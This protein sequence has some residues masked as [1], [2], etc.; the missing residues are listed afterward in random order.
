MRTETD[1]PAAAG[2]LAIQPRHVPTGRPSRLRWVVD[3]LAPY[4]YVAP[5]V[6]ILTVFQVAPILYVIFLS[7]HT[8]TSLFGSPWVGLHNYR[9]LLSDPEIRDALWATV[10]FTIGTVPI[11]ALLALGLALLLFEKL[12]GIGIFRTIVLLPF[13]TPVVATTVVWQ[14]IFNPQYGFLD[15]VLSFLHLST[16]DWFVSP[17]WSMVILVAYSLWHEIGFTVLIML[18][19]LTNIDREVREAARIDGAN[20]PREFLHITLPL[21]SPWIFFV[22]VVNMIGAFKVFTQ[23]L[24]LTGGGPGHATTIAGFLIEQEAFT[25]FN[26]PYASAIST[27]VL[28]LVSALTILQF[29][30]SRRAVFYQ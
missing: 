19:G 20:G 10:Q 12:P 2:V 27:A 25:Y 11:G 26:L 18:A 28:V 9:N 21:M 23:V 3:S 15:S 17:L 24:T 8:G 7:F 30:G 16:V 13:I 1:A 22:L 14:W 4:G 29:A 6:I 5:A